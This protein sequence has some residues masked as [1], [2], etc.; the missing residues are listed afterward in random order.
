[1]RY[2]RRH[3]GDISPKGGRILPHTAFCRSGIRERWRVTVPPHQIRTARNQSSI[4]LL[5]YSLPYCRQ[6]LMLV[7]LTAILFCLVSF[8]IR[9]KRLE[10][11]EY[12]RQYER[13]WMIRF[14]P[15]H[16]WQIKLKRKGTRSIYSH[17]LQGYSSC[18]TCEGIEMEGKARLYRSAHRLFRVET[19][20]RL[21]QWERDGEAGREVGGEREM[22]REGGQWAVRVILGGSRREVWHDMIWHD[23]IW[24]DIMWYDILRCDVI[25]YDTTT[26]DII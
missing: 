9:A 1:M 10:N 18:Q 8:C 2:L 22:G 13:Q 21:H 6:V 4:L 17:A 5:F 3:C 24:Y 25:W 7:V 15:I 26:Y 11:G 12:F 14:A 16:V 20:E 23:I 19:Y